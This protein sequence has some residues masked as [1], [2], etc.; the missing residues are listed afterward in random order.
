[1]KTKGGVAAAPRIG[2]LAVAGARV[3]GEVAAEE[4]AK[5]EVVVA[6]G[7]GVDIAE[8]A[9]V[10]GE[11]PKAVLTAPPVGVKAKGREEEEE[12]AA[13]AAAAAANAVGVAAKVAGKVAAVVVLVG[14]EEGAPKA[15]VAAAAEE[16]A[17]VG[18]NLSGILN[19]AVEGVAKR[20]VGVEA[21]PV[22]SAE[23]A[24]SA[25]VVRGDTEEGC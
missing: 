21:P 14:E 8:A 7:L 12:E 18:V 16:E 6:T 9:A 4:N 22:V 25:V 15:E 20:A 23:E 11:K 17:A 1:M 2:V 3:R 13:A 5:G 10:A 19:K 24:E